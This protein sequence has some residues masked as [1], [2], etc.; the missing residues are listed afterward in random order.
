MSAP[1]TPR[2]PGVIHRHL[3][4]QSALPGIVPHHD[5][6]P[7]LRDSI[8]MGGALGGSRPLDLAATR[9]SLLFKQSHAPLRTPAHGP[10]LNIADVTATA[11]ARV[12][13]PKRPREVDDEYDARPLPLTPRAN[14]RAPDLVAEKP[15]APCTPI[16]GQRQQTCDGS[17]RAS[18]KAKLEDR[19]KA[20]EKFRYKYTRAFPTFKFYFDSLDPAVKSSFSQ[21][22]SVLGARVEDFFSNSVTHFITNKFVP[23]LDEIAVLENK[24]NAPGS[25][26]LSRVASQSRNQ[27]ALPST[28]RSPIKLKST[29]FDPL[30]SKAVRFQMKIWDEKKFD[31]ILNRLLPETDIVPVH[32][33]NPT[34]THTVSQTQRAEASRRPT[35]TANNNANTLSTLLDAEKASGLTHERDP[36]ALRRDYRY[37]GKDSH[38]LLVED[39]SETH[40]PIMVK[41]YGRWKPHSVS[42]R[43]GLSFKRARAL[44]LED[45]SK[46]AE[47]PWPTIRDKPGK[48]TPLWPIGRLGEYEEE[49]D[50]NQDGDAMMNS[51]GENDG[52]IQLQ[53]A[54]SGLEEDEDEEEENAPLALSR[55]APGVP[56]LRRTA[57][58]HDLGRYISLN[59]KN[60]DPD[61]GNFNGEYIA[62]SGNSVLITSNVNSTTS[63]AQNPLSG[64]SSLNG[65]QFIGGGGGSRQLHN[66]RLHR[67]V[68]THRTLAQAVNATGSGEDSTGHRIIR[69]SKST[70]AMRASSSKRKAHLPARDEVKKPG[71]CENCRVKFED[72]N[73]HV[74][75]RRHQ[76][77]ANNED[78][79]CALDDILS[80]ITRKTLEDEEEERRQWE[81]AL[82]LEPPTPEES[83]NSERQDLDDAE[84]LMESSVARMLDVAPGCEEQW[85]ALSPSHGRLVMV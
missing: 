46:E 48:A 10:T 11:P 13:V 25:S 41:E 28:L 20:E 60:R 39:M 78:N 5:R 61:N 15:Q 1:T 82:A 43:H 69:K 38:W 40:A 7:S 70:N 71:Y 23:S 51:D 73:L 47:P 68:L 56:P 72:F 64:G 14:R 36:T 84:V 58:M 54:T 22:I 65:G 34:I 27:A 33:K 79:F 30:V 17:A 26:Q 12:P 67:Q 55:S 42:S 21:R 24:E 66:K 80:R 6:S 52:F 75:S 57:S 2:R 4:V 16:R 83:R 45:F 18:K 9:P 37:F 76:K 29:K 32:P 74:A 62:A 31:N 8:M 81:A 19:I 44:S 59:D 85:H 49:V 3:G 53:V 63:F 77:F 35:A 50:D